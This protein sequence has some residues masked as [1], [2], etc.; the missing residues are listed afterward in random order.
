MGRGFGMLFL[1]Q[2]RKHVKCLNAGML[3]TP[4]LVNQDNDFH[5]VMN[6]FEKTKLWSSTYLKELSWLF[7]KCLGWVD[8]DK[9]TNHQSHPIFCLKLDKN[10]ILIHVFE[11][12][13]SS[14]PSLGSVEKICCGSWRNLMPYGGVHCSGWFGWLRFSTQSN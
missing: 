12:Q 1:P 9:R 7:L 5:G 14:S 13:D 11:F 3:R 10:L 4:S 6:V 2:K 8:L